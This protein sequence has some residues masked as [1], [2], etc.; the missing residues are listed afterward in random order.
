MLCPA[1]GQEKKDEFKHKFVG[2]GNCK[3]CHS[4]PETGDQF[5]QW[6]KSPHAE[7]FKTLQG[8]KAKEIGAKLGIDDPS[9]SEK[10]VK[11][12]VTGFGAPAAVRPANKVKDSDGVGCET[13]HGAGG[14]YAKED[15]F[16][17]GKEAAIALGLVV[18]DEKLCVKCHNKESPSYKEFKFEEAA[19]KI[20]HPNPKKPKK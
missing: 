18:P 3:L 12:H 10:C 16:K 14:D 13:C 6:K 8:P 19:K 5:A 4:D 2:V 20:A 1:Y 11:C 17:K 15:V 7:A 9:K